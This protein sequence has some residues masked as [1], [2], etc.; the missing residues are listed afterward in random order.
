MLKHRA[1]AEVYI[2]QGYYDP[3]I[4]QLQIALKH[5]NG[6][7]YQLSTVEARLRQLQKIMAEEKEN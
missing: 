1:Q 3:A 5:D 6:D 4:E 2:L 7:F